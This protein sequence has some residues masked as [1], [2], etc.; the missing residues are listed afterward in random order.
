[1]ASW[2][3]VRRAALA[4]VAAS[5][6]GAT[7]LVAC[8]VP[9]ITIIVNTTSDGPDANPGDGVCEVT[10]GAGDCTVRAAIMESNAHEPTPM[11]VND[12]ELGDGHTYVLTIPGAAEDGAATGDLDVTAGLTINGH[13]TID[14]GNLD[15]VLDVFVGV[16][17][18]NDATIRNGR[19]ITTDTATSIGGGVRI[20]SGLQADFTGVTF[21]DNT[22]FEGGAVY[23]SGQTRFFSS[24]IMN[25]QAIGRVGDDG[26]IL[27]AHGGAIRTNGGYLSTFQSTITNNGLVTAGDGAAIAAQS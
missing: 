13:S 12:I 8:D 23:S 10:L 9:C 18:L 21:T 7:V 20:A 24:T 3:S 6:L 1:M 19:A 2:G 11:N 17:R 27:F 5:C 4:A 22:A 14:G 16:F 26:V 25:N 15:R